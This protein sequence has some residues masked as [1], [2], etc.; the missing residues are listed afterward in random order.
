MLVVTPE[1]Y[2]TVVDHALSG[3]P[4]EVCGILGGEFE[5]GHRSVS[6]V[7]Q[8][9]NTA[10]DPQMTYRI[11]PEE[12]FELMEDI[13]R[14]GQNVVGFYHSHP[15]GPPRPSATDSTQ[16]AW[17][18]YSYLIVVLSGE[19]PYVGSWKWTGEAFEREPVA[20]QSE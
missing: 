10:V 11:D 20:L 5:D 17:V 6:T 2:D 7:H 3:V 13:E 16:A 8:A 4:G 1:V 18:G 15:A 14:T 19:Y 9:T 12:Q